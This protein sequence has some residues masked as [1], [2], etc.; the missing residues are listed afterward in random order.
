MV[1]VR[2]LEVRDRVVLSIK[3][4]FKQSAGIIRKHSV[5]EIMA[6]KVYIRIKIDGD[7]VIIVSVRDTVAA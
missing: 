7:A 6:G 4:T 1:A 2:H 3:G 5:A